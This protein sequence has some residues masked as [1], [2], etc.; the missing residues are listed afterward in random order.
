MMGGES[1]Y[2][3][4]SYNRIEDII[5]GKFASNYSACPKCSYDTNE[6]IKPGEIYNICLNKI[7]NNIEL[8]LIL[9]LVFELNST[10]DNN[11]EVQFENLKKLTIFILN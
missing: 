2:I 1:S 9:T 7:I 5:Y 10:N 11:F 3:Y 6:K 4:V 8:P